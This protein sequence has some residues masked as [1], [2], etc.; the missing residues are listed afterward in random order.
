M[1]SYTRKQRRRIGDAF[2]DA[3]VV[4]GGPSGSTCAFYLARV[5]R[6]SA[7][8]YRRALM[9][10]KQNSTLRGHAL[11]VLVIEGRAMPRDKVCGDLIAPP[12]QHHLQ[13]MS[14]LPDLL[15]HGIGKWIAIAGLVGPR[16]SS[17]VCDT[18][19]ACANRAVSWWNWYEG[20]GGGSRNRGCIEERGAM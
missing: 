6:C 1:N 13:Q 17:F 18:A 5:R 4:G 10:D 8:R 11:R 14:L 3:I 9:I 19:S 2:F 12:A 15:A 7:R 16:G 20:D